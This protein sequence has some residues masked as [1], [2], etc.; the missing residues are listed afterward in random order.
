MVF[1]DIERALGDDAQGD[2]VVQHGKD[3]V[4]KGLVVDVSVNLNQGGG[5]RMALRNSSMKAD[6]ETDSHSGSPG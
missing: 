1:G 4:G 6:R 5:G 3:G 2:P